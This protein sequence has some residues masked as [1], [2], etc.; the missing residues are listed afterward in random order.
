[1][2][3]YAGKKLLAKYRTAPTEEAAVPPA[4]VIVAS[5]DKQNEAEKKENNNAPISPVVESPSLDYSVIN[6]GS[7]QAIQTV[8]SSVQ[9]NSQLPHAELSENKEEVLD[10][11]EILKRLKAKLNPS[12]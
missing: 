11:E 3:L 2:W 7:P 12:I 4:N 10:D 6:L 5:F 9:E 8:T 1:L